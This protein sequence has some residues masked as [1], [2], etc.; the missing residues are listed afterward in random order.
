MR[1]LRS[2]ALAGAI[3]AAPR[4]AAADE[5]RVLEVHFTP[6]DD[7]QIVAWLETPAGAFLDTLFITQLTGIYGLGNR[8]GMMEFNS[9]WAWPYGRRDTTF[10]IWAHRHGEGPFPLLV[11]QN[12]DDTNLSHP[13]AMSS[14]DAFFCRPL[15]PG[16]AAWDTQTCA[17]IVYTDKG[18]FSATE[19]SLYPPRVDHNYVAGTDHED[20][21]DFPVENPFDVVSRATPTG[22][23][24][25]KIVYSVPDA[26]VDGDYVAWIEVGK[27]FDQNGAYDYP[28]P[29]GI[30]WSEY[31]LAYR[32][33]PSVVYR[34]PFSIGPGAP[35]TAIAAAYAGYGDPDGIDGDVRAPDGTITENVDGSGASRLLL[36]S[37]GGEL[38][39]VRVTTRPTDDT[40]NPGIPDDFKAVS[41]GATHV[42]AT[43]FAPGNDDDIGTVAGYEIRYRA[44]E[45]VGEQDFDDDDMIDV[46]PVTPLEPGELQSIAF[47][48]LVPNTNY[49][50][51]VRAFDECLN[52]GPVAVLH[53][54]TPRLESAEVDACFIATAAYGSALEA[55]VD[56]LRGFRDVA[57]RGNAAGELIVAGYYTFGPAFAHAIR[58]SETLREVARAA[59][60]PAVR[61]A[62][63]LEATAARRLLGRLRWW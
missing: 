13:L 8:P 36:T 10:P 60:A 35:E 39:R 57:L 37:D 42:S 58:P 4:P 49:Y 41:V 11:F 54:K 40:R 43:F 17:S 7:L 62:R 19:T 56:A 30:P 44:G 15:R 25:H 46:A 34:V 22:N 33:Q 52:Y 45:P 31:G 23:I 53:A 16:E 59:L 21:L 51:A 1:L 50:F 12:L 29:S 28:S 32:G 6:T 18:M 55:E 26:M 9:A 47:P 63:R 5:C 14:R 3:A 38:F 61:M 20:V 27:E 24:L 48:N 2:L